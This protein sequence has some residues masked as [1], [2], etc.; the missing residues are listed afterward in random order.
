MCTAT[1]TTQMAYR[2]YR[3]LYCVAWLINY[4]SPSVPAFRS[5]YLWLCG[6]VQTLLFGGY[7]AYWASSRKHAKSELAKQQQPV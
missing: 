4:L 3:G 5:P 7:V 1:Q 2:G 6:T